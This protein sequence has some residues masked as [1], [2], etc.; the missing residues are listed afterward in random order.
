MLYWIQFRTKGKPWHEFEVVLLEMVPGGSCIV[1]ADI[2]LLEHVMIETAK[3]GHNMKSKDLIDIPQCHDAITSTWA[4]ILKYNRSSF[5]IDPDCS[6]NHD[7]LPN[8]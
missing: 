8:Q 3:I 4:N 1:G 5:M 2:V 6:P 7:V